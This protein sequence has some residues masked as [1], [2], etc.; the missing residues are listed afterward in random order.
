MKK[1]F[2]PV[3][4]PYKGG[5]PFSERALSVMICGN[6][7]STTPGELYSTRR[8][9]IIKY[10]LDKTDDFS[11]YGTGWEDSQFPCYKGQI[12]YKYEV[13]K[14]YKFNFCLE[15]IQGQKGYVTEKIF[16]AFEAGCIPI[17][18]GSSNISDYIPDNCYV[19]FSK[20]ESMDELLSFMEK[21]TE[22]EYNQY[23]MNIKAFLISEKAQKFSEDVYVKIMTQ[24]IVSL[25]EKKN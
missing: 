1:F 24:E 12:P 17:Y 18:L 7:Y 16:D 5:L 6:K 23:I 13:L 10:F 15:N 19:D 3:F 14:N 22:E 21:F 8:N 2:Y 11:L 25:L 20:F 9:I 4:L